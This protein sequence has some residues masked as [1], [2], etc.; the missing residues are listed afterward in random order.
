[1][2]NSTVKAIRFE[3]EKVERRIKELTQEAEYLRGALAHF[4]QIGDSDE[5]NQPAKA[6][7]NA[8]YEILDTEGSPLHY[9]E[10]YRRLQDRGVVVNGKNP[11]TNTIAHMSGDD[12]FANVQR[13]TWGLRKW[14]L[15][16]SSVTIRGVVSDTS[17]STQS[18]PFASEEQDPVPLGN[19]RSVR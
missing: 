14:S 16:K 2:A 3:L 6:V 8:I 7:R 5:V 9:S 4:E 1:M 19:Y 11:A 18:H 15:Q 10:I 17:D 12:R 13:G